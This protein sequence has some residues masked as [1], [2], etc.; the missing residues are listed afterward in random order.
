[1]NRPFSYIKNHDNRTQI[2]RHNSSNQP[3][4]A[5]IDITRSSTS[6]NST[7]PNS[8]PTDIYETV[9][10]TTNMHS[11]SDLA[12]PI[13]ETEWTNNL[14]RLMMHKRPLIK[15]NSMSV[16][17]LPSSSSTT[18]DLVPSI[19]YFQQQQNPYAKFLAN[20][21]KTSDSMR[22]TNILKRLKDDAAFLY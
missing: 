20:R 19:H 18:P 6:L 10:S 8:S 5:S 11:S 2:S 17:E 9:N 14:K 16:I 15:R 1:M 4:I 21:R 13:Y 12:T 7:Q 22:R 3:T